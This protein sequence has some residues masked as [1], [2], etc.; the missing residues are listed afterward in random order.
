M[1]EIQQLHELYR[2]LTG[3]VI[4]LDMARERDWFE[5]RKRGFGK[6]ELA[7]VVRHIKAGIR[8]GKRYPGA[9][10]FSNL[11]GMPDRF[12]EDLAQARAEGRKVAARPSPGRAAAVRASGREVSTEGKPAESAAVVSQRALDDLRKFREGNK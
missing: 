3:L 10:K 1:E 6:A 9:L 5:W 11:I 4:R 2:E 7:L 12:E 8:T